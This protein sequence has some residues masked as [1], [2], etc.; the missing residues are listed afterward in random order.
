MTRSITTTILD[1]NVLPFFIDNEYHY[2]NLTRKITTMPLLHKTGPLLLGISI[3]I[4][5]VA[6]CSPTP[7][8]VSPTNSNITLVASTNVWGNIAKQVGGSVVDVTSIISDPSQDPHSYEANARIQL[9][10]SKADVVIHNGGGYDD[11]IDTLLKS[12]GNPDVK[13]LNAVNISGLDQ[14]PAT[15]EFNEHVWYDFPTVRKVAAQ[16]ARTLSDLDPSSRATFTANEKAFDDSLGLLEAQQAAI[17]KGQP[18]D[19]GVA[20]TEPV[21][22]YL[23]SACG[24]VN[25]TPA[26]FSEAIEEGTDVRPTVLLQTLALFSNHS[27]KLLAYNEQTS[28]PETEQVLAAAKAAHIATISVTETLPT[29]NNYL[30]WMSDNLNA[31]RTALHGK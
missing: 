5:M 10:V 18:A 17:K 24:L 16:I 20:I 7:A 2:I 13:V 19:N 26:E 29:G 15:G 1:R 12:A 3:A 23:L 11:F 14:H 31:V 25:K 4:L 21:P 9:L 22:L 28:G 6:G 27:V 30:D 8:A